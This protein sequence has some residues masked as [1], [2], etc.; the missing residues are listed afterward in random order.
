MTKESVLKL[1]NI[2]EEFQGKYRFLSNFYLSPLVYRGEEYPTVE[3]AYQASK[4]TSFSEQ[5]EIK[6]ASTPG[7]AKRYGKHIV[8][9]RPDWDLVKEKIMYELIYIKFSTHKG[10]QKK[11]IGTYPMYLQEGNMWGDTFWGVDLRTGEGKNKL[12]KILMR[13]REELRRGN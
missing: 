4:T 2:I 7:K 6:I 12:G 9:L 1:K 11:L 5:Y 10:L 13:V 8:H 3:H